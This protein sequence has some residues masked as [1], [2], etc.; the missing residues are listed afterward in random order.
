MLS[1]SDEMHQLHWRGWWGRYGTPYPREALDGLSL[2]G[3]LCLGYLWVHAKT[4]EQEVVGAV[5]HGL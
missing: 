5:T 2:S 4:F 3:L 1:Y